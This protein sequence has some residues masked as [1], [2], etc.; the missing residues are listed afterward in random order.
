MEFSLLEGKWLIKVVVG[1]VVLL[2]RGSVTVERVEIMFVGGNK[3]VGE[4]IEVS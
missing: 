4:L 2:R 3:F 1:I